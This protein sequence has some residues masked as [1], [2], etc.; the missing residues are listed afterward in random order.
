[1][2]YCKL[3]ALGF[4]AKAG[5]WR[6]PGVYASA[7]HKGVYNQAFTFTNITT[8]NRSHSCKLS[9]IIAFTASVSTTLGWIWPGAIASWFKKITLST[10]VPAKYNASYFGH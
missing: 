1:M 10:L 3:K 6:R 2:N 7:I 9:Q 4:C 8:L 5:V